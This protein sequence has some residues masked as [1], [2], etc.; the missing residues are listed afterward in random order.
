[1]EP[2]EM[3]LAISVQPVV[4][5]WN[6]N[7]SKTKINEK[8][9]DRNIFKIANNGEEEKVKKGDIT[10]LRSSPNCCTWL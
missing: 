6:K 8:D 9:K 7:L 3:A 10:N 4:C 1:M 2:I 5:S